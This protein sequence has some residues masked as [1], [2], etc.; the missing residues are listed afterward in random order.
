MSMCEHRGRGDDVTNGPALEGTYDV[1]GVVDAYLRHRHD[2]GSPNHVME[3]PTIDRWLDDL[4]GLRVLDLGCGDGTFAPVCL[5]RGA[6]SYVGVDA[7]TGMIERARTGADQRASF[8]HAPIE[9]LP[10]EPA[11][12]DLVVSRLALHYVADLDAVL[13]ECRRRLGPDGRLVITV[14]H[15]VVSSALEV[16]SGP[17]THQAVSAYFDEG[18]KH[19]SWFGTSVTWFHRTIE[20]W[21]RALDTAGFSLV[22]LAECAPDPDRFTDETE[23]DRRR[24]VP[25][26][27]GLSARVRP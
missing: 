21:L 17:R 18:P 8:V 4:T 15:P 1:D 25:V 11:S 20:T 19:R 5:A 23:L 22:E 26:V 9:T 10:V 2:P 3:E 24:A 27:L 12:V 13:A 6:V 16:P 7:S 14:V